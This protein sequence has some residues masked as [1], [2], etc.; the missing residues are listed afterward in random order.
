[1]KNLY[2]G[3][4]YTIV[5]LVVGTIAISSSNSVKK[6]D[7]LCDMNN[8]SFSNGEK[9]VY[10]VYYNWK[11]IWVPAGEVV[12]R[13]IENAND[14][15]IK[16]NGTTYEAYDNFFRVRDYFYSKIDK[17]TLKPISFVR[18]VEEGDYRKFDS[19]AFHYH[20]QS[21]ISVVGKTRADA[22]AEY[23]K[24]DDC[25]H[26]LVSILYSMRNTPVENYKKGD[27]IPTKVFFDRE[28][29]PIKVKYNGKEKG[30]SIKD[31]GKFNAIKI[32]PDLV[33]GNV[34][35]DGA[36]MDIWVTDDGNKIPLLIE[37]PLKV[38]SGKAF[39]K[40]YTGLRHPISSKIK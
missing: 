40:S 18:L 8:V 24:L 30:K 35:T 37:S 15:E 22:K 1:M 38:G 33:A 21:A 23:H 39:L 14:Y 16:V 32:S 12:M 13:V 31:L 26:D 9:L 34:F 20:N 6:I 10:K 27:I 17:K 29:F 2:K 4:F 28:T 3:I 19:I 7:N 5:L 25:M 11:F 36:K